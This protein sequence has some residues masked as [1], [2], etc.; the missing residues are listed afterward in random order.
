MRSFSARQEVVLKLIDKVK[1]QAIIVT[2]NH[3][4]PYFTLP[5]VPLLEYK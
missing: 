5:T 2:Q 4:P 3:T 1:L